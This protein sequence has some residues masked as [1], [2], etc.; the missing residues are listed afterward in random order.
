MSSKP[1]LMSTLQIS[2]PQEVLSLHEQLQP[3]LH[4]ARFP[5]LRGAY[6][7]R[8]ELVL[9]GSLRC[10]PSHRGPLEDV[11]ASI[12]YSTFFERLYRHRLLSKRSDDTQN[13]AVELWFS[14]NPRRKGCSLAP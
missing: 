7:V 12:I 10:I 11:T 14:F 4:C 2:T 13:Q 8:R 6:A 5:Y 1:A 9:K 3:Q